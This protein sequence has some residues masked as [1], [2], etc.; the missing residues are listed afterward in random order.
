MSAHAFKKMA[1]DRFWAA[2]G[3]GDVGGVKEALEA[4]GG[5]DVDALC[6]DEAIGYSDWS[7]LMV[8]SKKDDYRMAE[9]LLDKGS[10]DVDLLDSR[11][12]SS[13]RLASEQGHY[14]L[15]ELL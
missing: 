12:R 14:N 4:E 10:A 7:A 8:A 3:N 11:R 6:E 2:V 13:L 1:T 15:V 5:I 9:L